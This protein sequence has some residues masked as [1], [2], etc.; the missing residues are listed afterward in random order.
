MRMKGWTAPRGWGWAGGGGR[1]WTAREGSREAYRQMA[2][3]KGGVVRVGSGT[4]MVTA[5]PRRR[6]SAANSM[7][8]LRWL[9]LW[10]GMRT[11]ILAVAIGELF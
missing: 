8:G 4:T 1:V 3:R 6:Q 9:M 10:P 5:R 11:T 7:M 2:E